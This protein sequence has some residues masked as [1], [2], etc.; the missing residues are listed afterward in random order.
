LILNVKHEITKLAEL[1]DKQPNFDVAIIRNYKMKIVK[2]E[3]EKK[4]IIQSVEKPD[5]LKDYPTYTKYE[6]D[7][8]II[9]SE[10]NRHVNKVNPIKKL[11]V[12]LEKEI[13]KELW[14]D[15]YISYAK[16]NELEVDEENIFRVCNQH[17]F[18]KNNSLATA[19][20]I[21]TENLET[22]I[23]VIHTVA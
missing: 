8:K 7:G 12:L 5:I 3:E 21:T 11:I 6:Y 15:R 16:E 18:E 4:S 17:W 9:S 13:Q 19:K 23:G 14:Y 22:N 2:L 20:N 10:Y 1:R